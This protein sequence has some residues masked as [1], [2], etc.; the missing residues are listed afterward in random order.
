MYA[1]F[2]PSPD[3]QLGSFSIGYY[4]LIIALSILLSYNIA[5]RIA[6]YR[7][8]DKDFIFLVTIVTVPIAI[9]G[10]RFLHVVL[11]SSQYSFYEAIAFWEGWAGL[12]IYGALI[13]GGLAIL[14]V[15]Y[16]KKVNFF[17]MLDV[18]VPVFLLAHALGRW[19]NFFNSELYGRAVDF[20][21]FPLTVFIE[22]TGQN[23][24]ALFFYEFVL[25]L[26]GF[27]VLLKILKKSNKVGIVVATYAI[28]YGTVR[29]IMEP[30]RMEQ[31]H[32]QGSINMF[33][34][35]SVLLIV[36]GLS[37]FAYMFWYKSKKMNDNGNE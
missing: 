2:S 25:N 27:F 29:L 4:G 36:A 37:Y 10:A 30:M 12:A 15:C 13:F 18:A 34:V 14:T 21:F 17:K 33:V 24:L 1:S 5:T 31:F 16:I 11:N 32:P 3:F 19:G 35:I 26:I 7:G 9:V 22:G 6:K 28:W 20:D 8:L 23:H